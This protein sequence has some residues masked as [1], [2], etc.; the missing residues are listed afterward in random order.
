MQYVANGYGDFIDNK[1]L[2]VITTYHSAKGLDF[3]K[4]FLPF[5]NHT[6]EYSVYNED[7]ERIFMVAMTRSRKDLIIS[8]SVSLD[9]Y[10]DN[11]TYQCNYR[12]LGQEGPGLFDDEDKPKNKKDDELFDF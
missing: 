8:F 11:F 4:V 1:D 5:C 9:H 2:V 10:V 7:K 12:V 6:D 3:D